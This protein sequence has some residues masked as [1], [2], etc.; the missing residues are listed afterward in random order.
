MSIDVLGIV[1]LALIFALGTWRSVNLGALAL[2][3]AVAVGTLVAGVGLDEIYEGFPADIFVLLVGMT[4]LFGVATANGTVEWVVDRAAHRVGDHAKVLPW[5]LFAVAAVPTTA[6]ALGPA[7]VAI[8]APLGL[9]LSQRYNINPVLTSLM[10]VHG[11]AVGNFSPVNVLGAI[12]N[13]TMEREGLSSNP[14]LL[15]AGNLAF[16]VMLGGVIYWIYGGALRR[17]GADRS[18]TTS[19]LPDPTGGDVA[20]VP[21]G[22]GAVAVR[23]AAATTIAPSRSLPTLT[24]PQI[25]TIGAVLVVVAGA[26]IFGLDIGVLALTA[27]VV[28]RLVTPKSSEGAEKS[29]SWNVVLLMCGII[30]YV[31]LLQ[32]I[33]T[34]GRIGHAVAGLSLP[35][36]AA[37]IICLIAATVSA[38]ASSAG[39][40]GALIPLSVP[41][42]AQGDVPVLGLI[43]ALAVSAT[44]VDATPFSTVGALTVANAPVSQQQRIFSG[45]LRWGLSMIIVAPVAAWLMFVLVPSL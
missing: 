27:A 41:L 6:G 15:F 40:L 31:A 7:G 5:V 42:L 43:I 22:S 32:H 38:F 20:Q 9:R 1:V 36:L 2:I 33:G 10:I 11:S 16:N 23:G 19:G 26:M 3:G 24:S 25:V 21:D 14:L 35:L 28:L 39:T 30:T 18:D 4:F 8:L 17:R 12:V 34:I 13:Q 44:A 45:I 37:F 29:I